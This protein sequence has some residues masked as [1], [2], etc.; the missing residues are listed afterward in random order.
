MSEQQKSVPGAGTT[1]RQEDWTVIS[2]VKEF[3]LGLELSRRKTAWLDQQV[4]R[5][6]DHEKGV[7]W[8]DQMVYK[9][10]EEVVAIVGIQKEVEFIPQPTF[11]ELEAVGIEPEFEHLPAITWL[12]AGAAIIDFIKGDKGW[13]FA[14]SRR[15]SMWMALDEHGIY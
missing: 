4:V 2:L 12:E 11:D 3:A 9:T 7:L 1:Q 14:N 15:S 10:V 6:C 13:S 8:A 5:L